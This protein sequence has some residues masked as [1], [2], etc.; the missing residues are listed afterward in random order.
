MPPDL[1]Q[2]VSIS[3]PESS[4]LF[5]LDAYCDALDTLS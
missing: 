2:R 4:N 1:Y 3:G 5:P